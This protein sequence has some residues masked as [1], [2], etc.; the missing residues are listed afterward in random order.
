MTAGD[1]VRDRYE[2]ERELGRGGTGVSYLARDLAS[3]PEGASAAGTSPGPI[4][5]VIKVLHVG[6]LE[7]WKTL[8]L[9]EREAAVLKALHHDRIPAYVDFF[10]GDLEGSTPLVLIREFV[11]GVSLQSK[12]EEGWRGTESEIT[13][14]ILQLI[15]IVQYIHDVRPAVI[16]R[17]INP[18]N[19]ILRDDGQ[20]FLVDFGGVQEALRL[21]GGA[22][23]TMVGTPGYVP[24]EQFV[25]RATIR[26]DLY[27]VAATLLFLLTHRNP[28]ELPLKDMKIDVASVLEVSSAPLSRLL[29][30]WL[31]PDEAKRTLPLPAA[32]DLLEG[33]EPVRPQPAR[34]TRSRPFAVAPPYGSRISVIEEGQL[35]T[36]VVPE[37]NRSRGRTGYGGFGVF[38]LALIGY[39]TF[40]AVRAGGSAYFALSTIPFWAVGAAMLARVVRRVFGRTS[41]TVSPTRLTVTNRLLFITRRL[42]VPLSDVGP[43]RLEERTVSGGRVTRGSLSIEVGARTVRFGAELSLREQ[44]WLRDA[45]NERLRLARI[46]TLDLETETSLL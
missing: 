41:L 37:A 28:A 46:T 2:I 17:D 12:V 13:A 22:T 10:Q 14:I 32:I 39:W 23:S 34:E 45:I 40:S 6:L 26:S 3:T 4:R 25:G 24:L 38:W 15:R 11:P 33:R 9:F 36:F 44:E 30:S 16:H 21:H 43:C 19:I 29:G 1:R 27:A 8:E 20:V 7:S 42:T 31:E 5:V 35:V 18:R